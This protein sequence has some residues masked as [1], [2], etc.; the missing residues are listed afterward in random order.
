MA[1]LITLQSELSAYLRQGIGLT[2]LKIASTQ[3]VSLETRLSIYQ[4][5][6]FLRMLEALTHNFPV[7]AHVLGEENFAHLAHHYIDLHPSTFKSIRWF[8]DQ[9][10]H[11]IKQDGLLSLAELAEFEWLQTCV[12]DAANDP[13]VTLQEIAQIPSESWGY[14]AFEVHSSVFRISHRFNTV[15]IWQAVQ[16]NQKAVP[17]FVLNESIVP[18]ILWRQNGLGRFSSLPQHEVLYLDALIA[19]HSFSDLL[20]LASENMSMDSAVKHIASLLKGWIEVG[21]IA[22]IKIGDSK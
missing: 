15:A 16:A 22:K 14:L 1:D 6:Y 3:N 5:A 17:A 21:L 13:V 18:W 2:H 11:F 8:G 19:G 4:D 7:L 20:M 10:A 12:F 9:L